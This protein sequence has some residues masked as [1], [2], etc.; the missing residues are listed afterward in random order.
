MNDWGVRLTNAVFTVATLFYSYASDLSTTT[1]LID[2]ETLHHPDASIVAVRVCGC[3]AVRLLTISEILTCPNDRVLE[4]LLQYHLKV[5]HDIAPQMRGPL[6]VNN[7][8]MVPRSYARGNLTTWSINYDDGFNDANPGFFNSNMP[9]LPITRLAFTSTHPHPI[10]ADLRKIYEQLMYGLIRERY[11]ASVRVIQRG[12]NLSR[13]IKHGISSH[14]L[15]YIFDG[16]DR[17]RIEKYLTAFTY[18]NTSRLTNTM[19]LCGETGIMCEHVRAY[20]DTNEIVYMD[21]DSAYYKVIDHKEFSLTLPEATVQMMSKDDRIQTYYYSGHVFT[22]NNKKK[23]FC[24]IDELKTDNHHTYMHVKGN[25]VPYHSEHLTTGNPKRKYWTV[26]NIHIADCYSYDKSYFISNVI[27][28]VQ[29]TE[30]HY[31]VIVQITRSNYPT[32]IPIMKS[33]IPEL[34]ADSIFSDNNW[35]V[36]RGDTHDVYAYKGNL[37]WLSKND[38]VGD[39]SILM[40]SNYKKIPASTFNGLFRGLPPVF[41]NQTYYNTVRNAMGKPYLCNYEDAVFFAQI[42]MEYAVKVNKIGT[43]FVASLNKNSISTDY[44]FKY[45]EYKQTIQDI[46]SAVSTLEITPKSII[47]NASAAINTINK[48]IDPHADTITAVDEDILLKAITDYVEVTP[49]NIL[50]GLNP[51]SF[52]KPYIYQFISYLWNHLHQLAYSA[53]SITV[54]IFIHQ[55]FTWLFLFNYHLTLYTQLMLVRGYY[56]WILR[57]VYFIYVVYCIRRRH[58]LGD[59][60]GWVSLTYFYV[61]AFSIVLVAICNFEIMI[62]TILIYVVII[63]MLVRITYIGRMTTLIFVLTIIMIMSRHGV[64]A[65]PLPQV[66]AS[67]CTPNDVALMIETFVT[68]GFMRHIGGLGTKSKTVY[69]IIPKGKTDFN[70][71]D[72][73]DKHDAV[74]NTDLKQKCPVGRGYNSACFKPIKIHNCF[75]NSTE[76]VYRQFQNYSI[77]L[78][79]ECLTRFKRWYIGSSQME[80]HRSLFNSYPVN[81]DAWVDQLEPNKRELYMKDYEIY[82]QNRH[83]GDVRQG[84][85]V[86]K[87]MKMKTKIDEKNFVNYEDLKMKARTLTEQ[88][89]FAKCLMGPIIYSL[90]QIQKHDIANA[91]GKSHG[92]L[93]AIFSEWNKKYDCYIPL[94]GSGFDSTQYLDIQSAVDFPLLLELIHANAIQISNYCDIQDAISVCTNAIQLV[95]NEYYTYELNGTIPSGTMKTSSLNG[96]RARAYV[97]EIM[98]SIDAW[99]DYDYNFMNL[100]DDILIFTTYN[101]GESFMKAAYKLTYTKFPIYADFTKPGFIGPKPDTK[102]GQICKKISLS[103]N[104]HDVDFLSCDFITDCYRNV[105]MVRKVDRMLQLT[106]WTDKNT[107]VKAAQLTYNAELL[108]YDDGIQFSTYCSDLPIY[109]TMRRT[110]LKYGKPPATDADRKTLIAMRDP[111][112]KYKNRVDVQNNALFIPDCILLFQHK[113]NITMSDIAD[114]EYAIGQTT[115]IFDT[116][117]STLFDK[118]GDCNYQEEYTKLTPFTRGCK[119]TSSNNRIIKNYDYSE[120]LFNSYQV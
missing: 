53:L 24:E 19:C 71:V 65:Q 35:G 62:T 31:Y 20:V 54:L 95:N 27:R 37:Y 111:G 114:F 98:E 84:V 112:D 32:K 90:M 34:T 99:E 8:N 78:N 61:S 89:G 11:E 76:S 75:R 92:E 79:P 77:V 50:Y 6:F 63:S 51:F 100:G 52:K 85:D 57:I 46:C 23:P 29:L 59:V 33:A 45:L 22:L 5:S 55:L 104:I 118:F 72:Q 101:L 83:P 13:A 119:L 67:G 68:F 97:R 12:G 107:A 110:L 48:M 117:S 64:D 96:E 87:S 69:A 25:S 91:S 105:K 74:D 41:T 47:H 103:E 120:Y 44:Q 40:T 7:F 81:F 88:H 82:C 42:V 108:A 39:I 1:Y 113:Y 36:H 94:D 49:R 102:L 106:P 93:S 56:I 17:D 86:L 4:N 73:C 43:A 80:K 3:G 28:K 15:N 14:C 30:E 70:W 58:R 9:G 2:G 16:V 38:I 10:L 18:S 116:Y 109:E 26:D 21:V 115:H 60:F 66:I